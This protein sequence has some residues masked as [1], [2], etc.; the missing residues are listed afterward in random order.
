MIIQN[1]L[2]T[3]VSIPTENKGSIEVQQLKG[4]DGY[5]NVSIY[6][7]DSLA[8]TVKISHQEILNLARS[9]VEVLLA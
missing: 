2:E 1:G 3:T 8:A 5:L 6:D 4:E 9:A 7:E